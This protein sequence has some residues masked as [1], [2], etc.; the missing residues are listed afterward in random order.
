MM[1]GRMLI[2]GA[3]AIGGTIGAYLRRSGIPVL[4]VDR[5][6]EHVATI[7][8]QGL[9]ITRPMGNFRVTAPASLPEQ[10]TGLF[11]QVFLCVKAQ[12]TEAALD[13]LSPLVAQ[14]GCVI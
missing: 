9:A 11:R 7:N 8:S 5:S 6:A 12:D 4:F 13:T 2:W 1:D 14:D 3:G 10:V